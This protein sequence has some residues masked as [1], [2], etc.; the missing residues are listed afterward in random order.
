MYKF[1]S[2]VR[3]FLLV[4]KKQKSLIF[5]KEILFIEM[6]KS[7]MRKPF[8]FL[9]RSLHVV[10]KFFFASHDLKIFFSPV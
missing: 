9:A 2:V 8:K 3:H 10:I 5:L 6:L 4:L 1:G 7:F